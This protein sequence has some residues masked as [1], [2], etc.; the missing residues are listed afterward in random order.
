MDNIFKNIIERLNQIGSALRTNFLDIRDFKTAQK[1]IKI[2][3]D[4][5]AFQQGMATGI[6]NVAVGLINSISKQ[7]S[8]IKFTLISDPKFGGCD[9]ELL[10]GLLIRPDILELPLEASQS[11]GLSNYYSEDPAVMF[12]VDGVLHLSI[13]QGTEYIYRGPR[14]LRTFYIISRAD[15]PK[16]TGVGADPRK[17][18]VS[19]ARIEIRSSSTRALLSL[20][21]RRLTSGFYPPEGSWRWTDGRAALPITLFSSDDVEVLIEVAGTT[22]YRLRDLANEKLDLHSARRVEPEVTNEL[23]EFEKTLLDLDFDF[24]L[25]NHFIPLCLNKIPILAINYDAIPA[26]FPEYFTPDAID[27]FSENISSFKHASHVFSIS[28]ASRN[29]LLRLTG[30]KPVDITSMLIDIDPGFERSNPTEVSR[31]RLAN[32]LGP[33]PY[34]ICVGTLEPRK[35]HKRLIEAYSALAKN[36]TRRCNLVIVGKQGWGTDDLRALVAAH[37][38][39]EHVYFLENV[40]NIDLRA[41]YSGALFS[42]Y[43]SLY[44]GFGLPIIEAMAC[45]CPVVTSSVSSMPEVAGDAAFYVDPVST[46]SIKSALR[47]MIN[48][49]DLRNALARKGIVRRSAFSWDLTAARVLDVLDRF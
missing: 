4:G 7:R 33:T 47:Q 16:Y 31:V 28:E 12:E 32:A 24:Y 42:V 30:K 35:N 5:G 6:Y 49:D 37:N 8:N 39:S 17:L 27:N 1:S 38:L 40:S 19:L 23:A 18:G 10:S 29:D 13:R 2:A 20:D 46:E 15:R 36:E 48:D 14:P 11:K 21:D 25:V 41:L 34:I 9:E 44:E 26:L 22:R 3:I 43:P 45:G